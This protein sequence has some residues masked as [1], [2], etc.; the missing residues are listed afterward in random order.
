MKKALVITNRWTRQIESRVAIRPTLGPRKLNALLT[1]YLR[2]APKGYN[3]N[4]AKR[5][6][7]YGIDR[8]FQKAIGNEAFYLSMFTGKFYKVEIDG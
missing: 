6:N 7:C 4:R 2:N 1:S 5:R 3:R 8:Q